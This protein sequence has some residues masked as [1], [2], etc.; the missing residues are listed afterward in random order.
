MTR[1]ETETPAV[2]AESPAPVPAVPVV[3]LIAPASVE[4]QVGD[5]PAAEPPRLLVRAIDAVKV[6]IGGIERAIA[7]ATKALDEL[8][9][10]PGAAAKKYEAKAAKAASHV[11]WLTIQA[12][13]VMDALRKGEAHDQ[14]QLGKLRMT[15]VVEWYRQLSDDERADFS[16]RLDRIDRSRRSR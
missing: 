15:L 4:L 8:I 10:A 2:T 11:A 5:E 12:A 16:R 6:G 7:A 14:D 1:E 9:P 13:K 3:A